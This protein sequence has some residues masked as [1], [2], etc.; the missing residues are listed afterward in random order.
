MAGVGIVS[1]VWNCT[2]KD[3]I[4]Y[5]IYVQYVGKYNRKMNLIQQLCESDI[6]LQ[7]GLLLS[8]VQGINN[9]ELYKIHI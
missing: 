2:K 5:F 3:Y 6:C 4:G 8:C 9:I 7:K 1:S